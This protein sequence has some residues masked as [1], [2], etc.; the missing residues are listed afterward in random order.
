MSSSKDVEGCSH[1]QF[2]AWKDKGTEINF[3]QDSNQVGTQVSET[4]TIPTCLV[5]HTD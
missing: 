2:Q 5:K 1:G 3:V 4:I